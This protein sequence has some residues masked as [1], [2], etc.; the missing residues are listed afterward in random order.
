MICSRNSFIN[1][2][3]LLLILSVFFSGCAGTEKSIVSEQASSPV[4]VLHPVTADKK[5]PQVARMTSIRWETS[6][7]GGTGKY[8][9]EFRL[10]DGKEEILEQ[11]GASSAWDWSPQ[12]AGTYKVRVI[13]RDASGNRVESAWTPEYKVLPELSVQSL[14]P[15]KTSPQ[16]ANLTT[17]GWTASAQGGAGDLS[18]EFWLSDGGKTSKLQ[19]GPSSTYEWRPEKPGRYRIKV[20]VR[21]DLHDVV[22]S[23][24]SK[25]YEVT[26]ELVLESL[27]PDKTSPQAARMTAVRWEA[28]AS[29]GDGDLSYEFRLSDGSKEVVVQKGAAATWNWMPQEAGTYRVMV[30]VRDL[31]GHRVESGWSQDYVVAPELKLHSMSPDKSPPQA[32]NMTTIRWK[33]EASGGVGERSYEFR[34][35]DSQVESVVQAGPSPFWDWTPKKEGRYRVRVFVK[36]AIGNTVRSDWSSE[37]EVTPELVIDSFVADKASPEAAK[38]TTIRWT[39]KASGG[40]GGRTYE[41][42]S[43]EGQEESVVQEGASPRWD[44]TPQ[45]AGTYKFRV[46]VRDGLGN[47]KQSD[48]SDEYQVAP[49][50]T[51]LSLSPDKAAPQASG[52]TVI[53]WTASAMGGVGPLSYEFILSDGKEETILQTGPSS[54]LDWAPKK[55]GVYRMKVVARDELGNTV[56]SNWSEDYEIVMKLLGDSLIAVFPFEKYNLRPAPVEEIRA[57]FIRE[58]KNKGM[59]IL[60]TQK[61][62]AFM[63]NRRVRYTGGINGALSE[64][65]REETGAEGL[66]ITSLELYTVSIPPKIAMTCRL[67]ST[68]K[69]PKILWMKTIGLTGDD[70]RGLLDLG[71]IKDINVLQEKAERILAGSL[72]DFLS[73]GK[74]A[75]PAA[76]K[77]R[78]Y[79]KVAY[80]SPLFSPKRRY[81]VAVIPFINRSNRDYA[82]NIVTLQ[83]V[84]KLNE[85]K[86]FEVLEPGQVRKRLLRYRIIMYEGLSLADADLLFRFLNVDMIVTGTVLDYQDT[87]GE[88]GNPKVD[89]S[90]VMIDKDSREVVWSSKNY[91]EGDEDVFFFDWGRMRTA[92]AMTTKMVR[93]VVKE[94]VSH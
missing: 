86:D 93:A 8:T 31:L 42:R 65:L 53:R 29:G 40:V 68:G 91:N 43:L 51:I 9:Y 19:E 16:T 66:L 50:L 44:W 38:M 78:F 70:A 72:S 87:R 23:G 48:W 62:D 45:K 10:S 57:S 92:S 2:T 6:A 63:E 28:S 25:E 81:R 34:V 18:Y 84:E 58:L 94:M 1:T 88:G 52:K 49:E 64:A 20:V 26:P 82:G 27:R 71:R 3:V 67:V 73:K 59:N 75:E 32:A 74:K 35:T 17:I 4:L 55:P 7:E 80:R 54:T 37:Y 77:K 89:F 14:T 90:A 79:P 36:D 39:A 24:W 41:F 47:M 83:F 56:E 69:D 85:S 5:S 22:E 60:P 30:I 15:D 33:A 13:V 76:V 46:I 61:L 12:T 11:M 21:D